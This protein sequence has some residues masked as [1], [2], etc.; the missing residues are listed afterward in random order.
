[1]KRSKEDLKKRLKFTKLLRAGKTDDVTNLILFL[2]FQNNY[3]TGEVIP[4]DGGDW[5]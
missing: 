3:I 1:M 2:L 4:I 5:I